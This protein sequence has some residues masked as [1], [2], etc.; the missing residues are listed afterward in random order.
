M[1]DLLADALSGT[2]NPLDDSDWLA[3]R[4]RARRPWGRVALLAAAAAVALFV[5]APGF[6]L[7]D[8]IEGSPAPP[9]ITTF[10]ATEN[11]HRQE[12]LAHAP[13]ATDAMRIRF[14]P[15]IV[16]GARG[17][18][19]VDSPDGPIYLWAAPTE[20]G[21]QCWLI[22]TGADPATGRPYGSGSCDDGDSDTPIVSDTGWT[23][24]RPSVEIV[25]TRVHDD[26]ITRVDVEV[27]GAEPLLL[28]VSSGHALGTL[29]KDARVVA[30]VGRNSDGDVVARQTL[31]R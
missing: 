3:V 19:A 13:A 17:V 25:H 29:P 31:S 5:V 7:I 26:A 30:Y 4:R 10:F 2:A 12:F 9:A 27:E 18:A 22:Q 21:G 11:V 1:T 20:D 28:P 14:S 23:I 6:G 24:E 15:T 16:G 8:L